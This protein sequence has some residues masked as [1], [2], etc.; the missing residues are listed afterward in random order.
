MLKKKVRL[1][2]EDIE[3]LSK[4]GSTKSVFGT[5]LSLRF[6]HA[7]AQTTQTVETKLS[8]TVSKKIASRAVDRVR[9]RRRLYSA[10]E[11]TLAKVKTPHHIMLM[12]K[13]DCLTVPFAVLVKEIEALFI[14]A[15]LLG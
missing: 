7:P 6:I 11:N 3:N 10:V 8:V 15:R 13:K 14:K 9:L 1:T 5:L 12:P 4:A 2:T